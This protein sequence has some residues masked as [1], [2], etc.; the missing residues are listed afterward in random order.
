M[1]HFQKAVTDR[2]GLYL[3]YISVNFKLIT[4]FVNLLLRRPNLKFTQNPHEYN[5]YVKPLRNLI[6]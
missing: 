2:L 3:F 6:H 1:L 5:L 4:V